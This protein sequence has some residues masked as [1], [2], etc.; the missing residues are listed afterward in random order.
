MYSAAVIHILPLS[1]TAILN[2]NTACVAGL[3]WNLTTLKGL[4]M[5]ARF[6]RDEAARFRGMADDTDREA[7][8]VR[9]LGMAADYEARAVVA[10]GLAVPRAAAAIAT[11]SEPNPGGEAAAPEDLPVRE[12]PKI[13]TGR[14]TLGAL[15]DTVS[16]ERRPAVRR[17]SE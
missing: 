16:V 17:R 3:G 14:I 12:V 5:D 2:S 9:L 10:D 15:K 1:P 7:T 8:R 6:L 11:V 4:T 13:R